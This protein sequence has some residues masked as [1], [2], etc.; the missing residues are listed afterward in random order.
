[1]IVLKIE[2]WPHGDSSK[3]RSLG[4]G[5]IVNEGTGDPTHGNYFVSLRSAGK[6]ARK[7]KEG[8]VAMFPRK[9]LL[10]WDL[11]YRALHATISYRNEDLE[12]PNAPFP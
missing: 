6:Q 2:L 1:M 9:R 8:K 4:L 7:W 10:A 11:I 3:A 12:A 5:I